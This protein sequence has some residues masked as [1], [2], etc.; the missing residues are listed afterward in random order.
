MKSLVELVRESP[1][2]IGNND[3]C[4]NFFRVK[5]NKENLMKDYFYCDKI[6]LPFGC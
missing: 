1:F 4:H 2:F 5:K 3:K 6:L